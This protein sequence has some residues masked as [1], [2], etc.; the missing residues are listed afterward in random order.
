ML[1]VLLERAYYA[2]LNLG[3]G[4][5]YFCVPELFRE[6]FDAL[7]PFAAVQLHGLGVLCIGRRRRDIRSVAFD[8]LHFGV[9]AAG[10]LH[11]PHTSVRSQFSFGVSLQLAVKSLVASVQ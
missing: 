10:L 5:S 9:Q 3:P 2:G 11:L 8:P 6:F 4:I 7:L 1:L